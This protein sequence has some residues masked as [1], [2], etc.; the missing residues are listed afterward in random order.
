MADS[1][2][3]ANEAPEYE[4]RYLGD[5]Q[6]AH[7]GPNDIGVITCSEKLSIQSMERIKERWERLMGHDHKLLILDGGLQF[8]VISDG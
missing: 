8:G 7:L 3:P 2:V 4:I 5:M 6:K 1:N